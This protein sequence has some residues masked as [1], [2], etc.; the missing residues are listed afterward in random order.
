MSEILR[1]GEDHLFG[2][3]GSPRREYTNTKGTR[4]NLL[5][6]TKPAR[7]VT[8]IGK[9]TDS[10]TSIKPLPTTKTVI[11]SIVE[12]STGCIGENSSGKIPVLGNHYCVVAGVK[13]FPYVDPGRT[14]KAVKDGYYWFENKLLRIIIPRK[15][16]NI[17][18]EI[19]VP[20]S[21]KIEGK[22]PIFIHANYIEYVINKIC[23]IKNGAQKCINVNKS[24]TYV[25]NLLTTPYV[26]FEKRT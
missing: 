16:E 18:D 8:N 5:S 9:Y 1:S 25:T 26:I 12:S 22:T 13:G 11:Q 21:T 4:I 19:V 2:S 20:L 15:A 14:E 7:P 6:I 3:G 23:Y 17:E 10:L 24:L